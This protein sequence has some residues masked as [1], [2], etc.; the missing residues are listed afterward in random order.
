MSKYKIVLIGSVIMLLLSPWFVVKAEE[1][2]SNTIVD[3]ANQGKSDCYE[4]FC[5]INHGQK[6]EIWKQLFKGI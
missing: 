3:M 6:N 5:G 1:I 2:D 4:G